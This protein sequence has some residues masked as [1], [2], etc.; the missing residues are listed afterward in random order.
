MDVTFLLHGER[1]LAALGRLD[2]DQDFG[3]FQ[4]GERA[5]ILQTYLRLRAAGFAVELSD[6][7]PRSGLLVFDARQ[8]DALRRLSGRTDGVFL[9]GCRRDLGEP[10]IADFEVLQNGR[11]ADSERRFM[12]PHWPQPGLV[13]RDSARGPVIMRVSYKGFAGN[14]D[15]EFLGGDWRRFL[16]QLGIQWQCDAVPYAGPQVSA[17]ETRWHDFRE[18]D[19]VLA[20]RPRARDLH[21][22]KPATKL[23]NAWLAGVPAIL[24]VEY[25]YRELRRNALDYIEVTSVTEAM[26]AVEG[27][28]RD[29]ALF[30]AMVQNGRLRASEFMPD[31]IR[32]IWTDLLF[33]IL[34][35]RVNDAR[36][37]RWQG[38]PL[39][40]KSAA[41]RV[42]RRF[43][44]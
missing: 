28:A 35:E 10:L 33:R 26:Q 34:P 13:P 42:T 14:L 9:V 24:G 20:V 16:A 6:A 21:V 22:R 30:D 2:A 11:F 31:A 18:C 1:A 17:S 23:Y 3:E 5:W 41:R 38:K 39:W 29:P 19:V 8:K 4:T 25:A 37:R 12:V 43:E 44:R 27:L 15:P 7:W 32:S 36:A 40:L